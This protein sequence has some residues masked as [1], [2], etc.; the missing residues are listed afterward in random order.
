[1]QP[2]AFNSLVSQFCP[3]QPGTHSQKYPP[4]RLRHELAL[5]QGLL[6]HSLASTE[7]EKGLVA[8]ACAVDRCGVVEGG[9]EAHLSDTSSPTTVK[10]S[11]T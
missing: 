3:V 6:S 2:A 8:F 7:G 11:D 5:T 9:K 4:I 10:D 1:M